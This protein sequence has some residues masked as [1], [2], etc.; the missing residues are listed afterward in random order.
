MV[1]TMTIVN[2]FEWLDKKR[3]NLNLSLAVTDESE[4]QVDIEA[5]LSL[6]EQFTH[7]LEVN[8]PALEAGMQGEL[9]FRRDTD[10]KGLFWVEGLDCLLSK[11]EWTRFC[12]KNQLT[13]VFEEPKPDAIQT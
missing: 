6:L 2:I 3:N 9:R 1:E 10:M 4:M 5:R 12:E 8:R 7:Y 11:K 13:A